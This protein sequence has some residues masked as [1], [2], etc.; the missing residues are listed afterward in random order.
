VLL[1]LLAGQ[2]TGK[3]DHAAQAIIF[4]K[5]DEIRAVAGSAVGQMQNPVKPTEVS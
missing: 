2:M 3:P 5:L 4:V 1:L